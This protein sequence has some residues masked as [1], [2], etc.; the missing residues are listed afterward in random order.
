MALSFLCPDFVRM[1]QLFQQRRSERDELAAE[2]VM[3]RHEVAVLRRQVARPHRAVA[4]GNVHAG[5]IAGIHPE[6]AREQN[7]R[8][9]G[10]PSTRSRST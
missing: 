1:L 2:V 9:L 7:R 3:L 5:T 10:P 8:G 6:L 4:S